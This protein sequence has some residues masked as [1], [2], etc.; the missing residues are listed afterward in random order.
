MQ[1]VLYCCRHSVL[2]LNLKNMLHDLV[3]I[4]AIAGFFST[5]IFIVYILVSSRHKE[6]MALLEY[7]KEAN[8]FEKRPNRL[9]AIKQGLVAAMVGVGLLMGNV[10]TAFGMDE[11]IV[12][13][14]M[15]LIMGGAGLVG[16]HLLAPRDKND[17]VV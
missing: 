3:P 10:M 5:V 14:A 2:R 12:Y 7:G 1:P 9:R 11:D 4:V 6:R 15:G 16:F 13:I 8:V 17:E